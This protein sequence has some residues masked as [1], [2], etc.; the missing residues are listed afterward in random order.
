MSTYHSQSLLAVP[1]LISSHQGDHQPADQDNTEALE[2]V[3]LSTRTA[4]TVLPFRRRG[5]TPFFAGGR[6]TAAPE[7]KSFLRYADARQIRVK[8]DT[9][10]GPNW[11]PSHHLRS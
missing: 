1:L 10:E 8:G 4:P 11:L 9:E 7:E 3:V 6:R 2:V 5:W